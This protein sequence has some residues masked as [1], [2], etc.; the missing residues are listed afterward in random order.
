M[1]AKER[2]DEI[3]Q[4][5]NR[6]GSVLVKELAVKYQVTEDSIRKDL[7]LLQKQG[8]LKKTYGGAVR[9]KEKMH[10]LYVSQRMGKNI[11]EKQT[12]AACAYSLIEE[13]DMVFLDTS[14]SNIELATLI[15]Q[16]NK[17]VT[18]VTNMIE[19]MMMYSQSDAPHFIFLGGEFN[20]ERDAFWGSFTNEL[21]SNFHFDKAFLGTVGIDLEA[22][23]IYNHDVLGALTKRT[24]IAHSSQ[25]FILVET[26]KLDLVGNY[27]YAKVDD[28]DGL[29]LER[30]PDPKWMEKIKENEISILYK[31]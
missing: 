12:I 31:Q 4:T 21:I 27:S 29:I 16:G 7:T 8:L 10:D 18:V 2:Q 25:S 28:V 20:D 9:I 24:V 14:T 11:E 26:R 15:L 17:R 30:E 1:L 22:Q 19:I 6:N 3:V 5:V 23:A 13:G